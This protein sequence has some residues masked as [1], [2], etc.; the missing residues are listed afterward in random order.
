MLIFLRMKKQSLE[1]GLKNL[2]FLSVK[3]FLEKGT[4]LSSKGIDLEFDKDGIR[5]IVAIKSGPNWGNGIIAKMII[6][7]N[8][9][10]KTLRTSNSKLNII[11]VNGCCYGKGNKSLKSTDYYKYCGQKFWEFISDDRNLYTEIIEPLGHKA[12]ENN[13][14][15]MESYAKMINKFTKQFT[16]DFCDNKKPNVNWEKLVKFN[17]S[18]N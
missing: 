10:K 7:F 1:T 4:S 17:S 14:E 11:A 13:D 16:S 12:R 3:L 9:T 2:L 15:F 18:I 6:D 5:Y 8:A